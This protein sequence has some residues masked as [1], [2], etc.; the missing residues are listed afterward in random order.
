MMPSVDY[1]FLQKWEL[2]RKNNSISVGSTNFTIITISAAEF[3]KLESRRIGKV[4]S[5]SGAALPI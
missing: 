2:F 1:R 4:D 3:C 5:V